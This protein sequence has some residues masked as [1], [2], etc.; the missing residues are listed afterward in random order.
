MEGYQQLFPFINQIISD[1]R[2]RPTH[3]ALTLALCQA[4]ITSR[5]QHDYYVSRRKLMGASRIHSKATYH[6]ILRELQAFGYVKYHPSYHPLNGS[7]VT[8]KIE[9]NTK[10]NDAKET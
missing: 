4:W 1:S 7:C 2:L 10:S 5:C 9:T 3:I 8:L 6:K